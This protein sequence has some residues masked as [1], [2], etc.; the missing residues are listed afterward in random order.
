MPLEVALERETKG[1]WHQV[2]DAHGKQDVRDEHRV[3]DAADKS[4][5]TE[6]RVHA[7]NQRLVGDVADQKHRRD[8]SGRE[9]Q[10]AVRVFVSGLDADESGGDEHGGEAIERGVDRRYVMD[11]HKGMDFRK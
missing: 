10:G 8:N 9:H 5:A 4:F 2:G 11:G 3:I 6:R 1:F 7:V